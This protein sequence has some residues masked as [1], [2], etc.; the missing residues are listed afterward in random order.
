MLDCGMGWSVLTGQGPIGHPAR[1][2]GQQPGR[3]SGKWGV[4][5]GFVCSGV[6]SPSQ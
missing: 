5:S 2:P 6:F 1:A 3:S 4:A